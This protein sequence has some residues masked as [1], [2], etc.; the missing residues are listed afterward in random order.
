MA[1]PHGRAEWKVSGHED[2][3]FVAAATTQNRTIGNTP[4]SFLYFAGVA[5]GIGVNS[6]IRLTVSPLKK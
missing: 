1:E 6:W 5:P 4:G 2:L 3:R